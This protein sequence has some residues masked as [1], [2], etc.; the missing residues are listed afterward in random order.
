MA[1]AGFRSA[2]AALME[3][4]RKESK[5]RPALCARPVYPVSRCSV[6]VRSCVFVCVIWWH[7]V[8]VCLSVCVCAIL[9]H[10]SCR[11]PGYFQAS[12][13]KSSC[14]SCDET[15]ADSYQ[16][17]PGQTACIECAQNTARYVGWLNASSSSSCQ[18]KAGYWRFNSTCIKCPLGATCTGFHV[19][20]C[21]ELPEL[22]LPVANQNFWTPLNRAQLQRVA[23][24]NGHPLPVDLYRSIETG[25]GLFFEC[26]PGRCQGGENST[27]KAGCAGA[28]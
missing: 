25:S 21:S 12:Q 4:T 18:C 14:A 22:C 1:K 6:H 27:C 2:S 19:T 26:G 28:S 24:G 17:L 5:R 10:P 8:C 7:P 11:E 16:H 20:R 23:V 3:R 15:S 9:D 13:N